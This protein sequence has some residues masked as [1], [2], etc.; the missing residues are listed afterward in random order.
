MPNVPKDTIK[1]AILKGTGQL[2]GVSYEEVRYEGYGV[3]GA[4]L[5]IDCTTDNK[6][7]TVS[8][9]RHILTSNGGSL[10]TEG[11]VAFMFKHC[12]LIVLPSGADEDKAMEVGLEAG[13]EDV[14]ANE[15]GHDR[16]R[17]APHDPGIRSRAEG[18]GRCR[19]DPH[20]R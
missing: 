8:D 2:E 5:I 4:A 16:N 1:N 11:S 3:S 13:A 19:H 17:D 12:G 9:V 7:R 18:S 10:G 15:D 14:V 6:V 20:L